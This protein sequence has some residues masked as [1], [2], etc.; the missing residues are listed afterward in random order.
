MVPASDPSIPIEQLAERANKAP[1]GVLRNPAFRLAMI[2]EPGFLRRMPS[3]ALEALAASPQAGDDV[4]ADIVEACIGEE[5]EQERAIMCLALRANIP[6]ELLVR[7]GGPRRRERTE[8]HPIDLVRWRARSR[9]GSLDGWRAAVPAAMSYWLVGKPKVG[10]RD[11]VILPHVSGAL[12]HSRAVPLESPFVQAATVLTT[13]RHRLRM[14]V[15]AQGQCRAWAELAARAEASGNGSRMRDDDAWREFDAWRRGMDP[16]EVERQVVGPPFHK[17]YSTRA[18]DR[19]RWKT[20][21]AAW[22]AGHV[23]DHAQ[24]RA[25]RYV[26]AERVSE[27]HAIKLAVRAPAYSFVHTL[28]LNCPRCPQEILRRWSWSRH[29]PLRAMVAANPSTTAHERDRLRRDPNWIVRG[30]AES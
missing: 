10:G 16:H 13:S 6:R 9:R 30:A 12:V 14:A 7:L 5:V 29:W 2:A 25:P 22:E 15:H 24:R 17:L 18:T 1:G 8:G 3:S 21:S 11:A 26:R 4:L 27:R 28:L 20:I 23:M 19:D